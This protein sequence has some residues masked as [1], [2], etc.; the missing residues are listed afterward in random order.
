MKPEDRQLAKVRKRFKAMAMAVGM[1]MEP[2]DP[3]MWSTLPQ[4]LLEL[5][6]ARLPLHC[7]VQ[8]R[9]LSK[10]WHANIT[11]PAFQHAY[12]ETGNSQRFAVVMDSER[13][14]PKK[15]WAYDV[16]ERRWNGLPLQ[17]LPFT[18]LVAAGGGLLCF[19]KFN[20][21]LL[22]RV[23]VCNPLTHEWRELPPPHEVKVMPRVF[24]IMVDSE[25]KQYSIF[26]I[27]NLT[28]DEPRHVHVY[29]SK[30]NTWS[31]CLGTPQGTDVGRYILVDCSRGFVHTCDLWPG[32]SSTVPL[33]PEFGENT[34]AQEQGFFPATAG[35]N[36]GRLFLLRMDAGRLWELQTGTLKWKEFCRVPRAD[37]LEGYFF[38]V[39][40][41]GNVI[42][43][44][45]ERRDLFYGA[46]Y[47][48]EGDEL[49]IVDR[50]DNYLMLMCDMSTKQWSDVTDSRVEPGCLSRFIFELKFD[51]TP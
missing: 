15:V 28:A 4:G 36:Q 25:L 48:E 3:D 18:Y 29:S 40:A 33:P 12:R 6:F 26:C 7:I 1:A 34:I 30:S 2:M 23:I 16:M 9:T 20:R 49:K 32:A 42:L 47:D 50:D 27:E 45:G 21:R 37:D 22:G 24:H 38:C 8:L 41:C 11:L 19:V 44:L 10:Q 39:F 46:T 13:A 17:Y 51:A 35:D 31:R 5:I 14:K 43:L